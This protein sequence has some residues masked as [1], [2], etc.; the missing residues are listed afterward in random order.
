MRADVGKPWPEDSKDETDRGGVGS[1]REFVGPTYF[2]RRTAS[3]ATDD[4]ELPQRTSRGEGEGPGGDMCAAVGTDGADGGGDGTVA[5]P[6]EY[7]VYKRRWF[8]LVQLTLLNI[9]VSWD[10]SKVLVRWKRRRR[11]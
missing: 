5:P 1:K 3:D 9:I 8:G 2:P 6:T 4:L 7:K 10:V 11:L